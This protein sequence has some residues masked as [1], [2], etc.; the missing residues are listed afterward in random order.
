VTLTDMLNLVNRQARLSD[1]QKTIA[2]EKISLNVSRRLAIPACIAGVIISDSNFSP[3]TP[4][5]VVMAAKQIEMIFET[6]LPSRLANRPPKKI[7]RALSVS[8]ARWK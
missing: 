1:A 5:K 7:R 6:L 2:D 3:L 8:S 4:R